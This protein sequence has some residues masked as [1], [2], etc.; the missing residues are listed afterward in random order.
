MAYKLTIMSDN[1]FMKKTLFTVLALLLPMLAVA[2][3]QFLTKGIDMT[4]QT[5][6]TGAQLNQLVDNATIATPYGMVIRTNGRPT[7]SAFSGHSNY[8]W[9]DIS[10]NPPALK[11]YICCGDA[12][13]NWLSATLGAASV[14]SAHLASPAVNVGQI[15]SSAIVSSNLADNAVTD[16]K[17]SAGAVLNSKI[18]SGAVSNDN[19]AMGTITGNRLSTLTIT[20]TNLASGTITAGKLLNDTLTSNQ[21]ASATIGTVELQD[22]GVGTADMAPGGVSSFLATTSGGAVVWTNFIKTATVNFGTL[23]T[24]TD[25]NSITH[26]VGG[27]PLVVAAKLVCVTADD[28]YVAGDEVE[29]WSA[30]NPATTDPFFTI[31]VDAT[32]V[33]A[34]HAS[35]NNIQI[36]PRTVGGAAGSLNKANW[37]LD[38]HVYRFALP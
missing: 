18:G 20:D 25:S 26:G 11:S 35:A 36:R 17:I 14:T 9:L 15:F 22:A 27:I 33:Y 6:V 7:A 34:L 4:A 28:G 24:M 16:S 3:P 38:V 13:T 29:A 12:D 5:T 8:L 30:A 2:A 1:H 23:S 19:I 32:R 21:I 31:A 10:V 37:R